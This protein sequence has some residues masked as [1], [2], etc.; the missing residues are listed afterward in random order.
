MSDKHRCSQ[1]IMDESSKDIWL[2]KYYTK[3]DKWEEISDDCYAL[4]KC[5]R[6]GDEWVLEPAHKSSFGHCY[7]PGLHWPMYREKK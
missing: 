2:E 1:I 5:N 3:L 6:F 4:K 7:L